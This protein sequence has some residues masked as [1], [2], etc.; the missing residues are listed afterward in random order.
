MN[1]QLVFLISSLFIVSEVP[2][3][4]DFGKAKDCQNWRIMNDGVMGGLS[5][6]TI[7]WNP[8]SLEFNGNISTANNSGF[9]S[10]RSPFSNYDLS[11][12][13]GIKIKYKSN[14][15]PTS[16]VLETSKRWWEPYYLFALPS[17]EDWTVM[18]VKFED[19]PMI[20]M[21]SKTKNTLSNN[22]LND[23]VRIGFMNLAKEEGAFGF[24]VDFME[25][26]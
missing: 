14:G 8:K 1:L 4:Y 20:R 26:Y 2:T 24:E 23:I 5:D 22:D 7:T 10:F 21:T 11:K 6:C 16:I 13:E 19:F 12:Y 15:L 18:K 3:K 25:F 9:S 17:S